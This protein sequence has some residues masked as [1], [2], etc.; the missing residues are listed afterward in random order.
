NGSLRLPSLDLMTNSLHQ[1]GLPHA[2]A[3]V[4]E[5]RIVGLGGCLGH[6]LGSG[7]LKLVSSAGHERFKRIFGIEMC[8]CIPVKT[9]L[10]R[11]SRARCRSRNGSWSKFA[12]RTGR[13]ARGIFFSG[14]ELNILIFRN[15]GI[16]CL[17]NEI[18]EFFSNVAELGRGHANEQDAAVGMAKA[19]GL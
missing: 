15:N 5:Q 17:L 10:F 4:E 14:N 8:G 19:R 1:V 6:R 2:N 13:Y 18:T 3:A 11:S 7:M 12:V 9:L 16:D